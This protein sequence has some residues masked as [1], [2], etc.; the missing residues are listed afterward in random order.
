MDSMIRGF[1]QGFIK[2]HILHH[3]STDKIYGLWFIEE[4]KR[5]GYNISPGTLYPIFHTLEQDGL[6]ASDE[7][8]VN[9]KIRKY[10]KTTSKGKSTLKAATTKVQ[11]LLDELL[12]EKKNKRLRRK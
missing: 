6:L 1:F 4:L 9:G 2:I 3:A 7:K 5:H 10:Y 11:E 8:N 12:E